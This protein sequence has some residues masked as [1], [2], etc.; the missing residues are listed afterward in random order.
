MKVA[1]ADVHPRLHRELAIGLTLERSQLVDLI[2]VVSQLLAILIKDLL[3]LRI[4]SH[5]L[6]EER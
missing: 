6:T 3:Y 4:V 5:L 1:T 2:V